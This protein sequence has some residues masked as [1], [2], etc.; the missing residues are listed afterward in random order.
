[1]VGGA[2]IAA[3]R[4]HD[5]LIS[6]GFETHLISLQSSGVISEPKLNIQRIHR[7][8]QEILASKSLTILQRHMIQKG[9]HLQTPLSIGLD[10][11]RFNIQ[12]FDV[13]HLHSSY[14][15]VNTKTL[16]KILE[17]GK[18]TYITLHDQRFATG[19]CHG[20]MEC[21]NYRS[22]CSDCPQV[23][24]PFK[25]L[26]SRKLRETQDLLRHS[27]NSPTLITPSNWLAQVASEV[28]PDC[29]FEIVRNCVPRYLFDSIKQK[30]LIT[31]DEKL[32]LGFTSLD[33]N[34]PY[35]GLHVLFNALSLLDS[36]TRATIELVL[37]G[38][39]R[40]TGIPEGLKVIQT[41]GMSGLK[42]ME[43]MKQL[44][45]LLL[46]STQDNLPNVM[47]EALALGVPVIG[48]RIGGITE[49]LEKFN[50][51]TFEAGNSIELA[52][53]L[54]NVV[55]GGLLEVNSKLTKELFS[56]ESYV[57]AIGKI[58]NRKTI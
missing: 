58:Y 5:A 55:K 35:K 57:E 36:K 43:A 42:L 28:F 15:L 48:S 44:D 8:R 54:I 34:N 3:T 20:S 9:P 33:L 30:K 53:L 18:P 47:C 19:G 26:I 39:G 2:G 46:P 11:S 40:V 49:I 27:R 38:E 41:G 1:M 4:A 56:M 23:R 50:L 32:S 45:V 16:G 51:P 22:G 17:F 13:V 37:I 25:P 10:P 12:N 7:S 14:N 31:L 24:L 29:K 6:G 21:R 52:S